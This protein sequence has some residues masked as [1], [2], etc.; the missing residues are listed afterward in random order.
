MNEVQNKTVNLFNNII[1]VLT[2]DNVDVDQ[3]YDVSKQ[4][5][6]IEN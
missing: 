3:S 1:K 5:N 6:K 2:E 4:K